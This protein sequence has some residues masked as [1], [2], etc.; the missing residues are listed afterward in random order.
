MKCPQCGYELLSRDGDKG[1]F[2]CVRCKQAFSICM[3]CAEDSNRPRHLARRF[4]NAAAA[5][6]LACFIEDM[7]AGQEMKSQELV[8]VPT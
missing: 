6:C 7:R 2:Q 8:S 5:R 1:Q 4:G 3:S